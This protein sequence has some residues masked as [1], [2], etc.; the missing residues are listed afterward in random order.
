[1]KFSLLIAAAA[2]LC[3]QADTTDHKY[4]K[5]EHIEL[6]V[7]KVGPYANPQE[8]YEYYKLP[9]CAPETKHHPDSSGGQGRWNEWKSL[10]MGEHLGGHALRH[11]GHDIQFMNAPKKTRKV[12]HQTSHQRRSGTIRSSYSASLVLSNVP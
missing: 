9:Y 4:T 1:M 2:A 11:S 10:T 3:V 12:Y 6:W 5:N 8:A 7:N